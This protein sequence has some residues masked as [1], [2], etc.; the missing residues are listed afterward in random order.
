MNTS[1]SATAPSNLRGW[2]LVALAILNL[3]SIPF[4]AY[5]IQFVM[6]FLRLPH[7]SSLNAEV[8]GRYLGWHETLSLI[9]AI[10]VT[11]TCIVFWYKSFKFGFTFQALMVVPSICLVFWQEIKVRL[12]STKNSWTLSEFL[13]AS[14]FFLLWLSIGVLFALVCV[15]ALRKTRKM[16]N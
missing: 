1:S 2:K 10:V 8:F 14:P 16:V 3:L 7:I 5:A 13:S 9:V 11:I 12:H 4:Y 15:V 6:L